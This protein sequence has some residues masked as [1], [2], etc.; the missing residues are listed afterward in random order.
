MR[1]VSGIRRR[2]HAEGGY[3][4]VLVMAI[5]LIFST[6]SWSLQGFINR[7]FLTWHSPESLA[8]AM[9]AG[10]VNFAILS[11][12]IATASYVS[13]FVAQYHGSGQDLRVG[14]TMWQAAPIAIFAGLVNLA[15]IPAAPVFFRWVGHV[16]AVQ[17]EEITL[18]RILCL[19]AFP[20][21]MF[22][23][24]SGMLSGLGRTTPVMAVTLAG[25]A[26]NILLD[27]LQRSPRRRSH[28]MK[29][30]IVVGSGAG[31]A[32]VA[33]ELAGSFRVTILEEGRGFRPF[34]LGMLAMERLKSSGLL[35]DERMTS[36]LFPPMRI[37]RSRQGMSLVNGRC[38]GGTTTISAGNA[39]R[40]D[41]DLRA[42]GI[43]LDREFEELSREV[44]VSADHAKRWRAD[45]RELFGA[46]SDLGLSPRPAPK[47]IDFRK[48]RRCGRCILGCP[49]GAKWDAR[50]FVDEAVG[51]GAHL[52]DGCRVERVQVEKGR[53]TGV[54]TRRGARRQ[55]LGADLVVIAAGGLGSPEVLGR[56]GIRTEQTL[57]VDPVLCLAGRREGTGAQGEI[58]MPFV[59]QQDSFIL[60]PYFD[61][62]SYFFNRAW[63]R[64]ES[65]IL[66]LMVKLADSRG[67]TAGPRGIRKEL[68]AS[69]RRVLSRGIELCRTVLL[70]L[71]VAP[72]SLV[73]GTVNAGHPGGTVP[74]TARDAATLHPAQLPSNLYVADASLLPRSLGNPPI[75]T[76]MALAKAIGRKIR[77]QAA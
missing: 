48:C 19:G 51:R 43:D 45:T 59:V 18:F 70:R 62:L 4:Q 24:L 69:D 60:S 76:V 47:L 32:T 36:L 42:I 74:L 66:S 40:M 37:R 8:A 67:G 34:A 52:L 7:M 72:G 3:R 10:M 41:H 11:I 14:R 50:R 61:Y 16:P 65:G 28:G 33:R 23:A 53:A 77:E 75:L 44:P 56:S 46:C 55:F 39:L 21:V 58:S 5:P 54:W 35:L 63:R 30:A 12:F 38:I 2:W 64:P 6:G 71:G 68:S 49:R 26:V 29:T 17:A 9:P 22:N 20:A 25:T 13:T 1:L 27:Y 73:L 31:G 15:L 57:F